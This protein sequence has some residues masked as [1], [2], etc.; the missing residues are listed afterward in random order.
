[1]DPNTGKVT[2][3]PIPVLKKGFPMGTLDLQ[4]DKEQ[5]LWVSL[6]YQGGIAKFD[7]KTEQFQVYPI[8]KEWQGNGTQ[9]SMVSPQQHRQDRCENQRV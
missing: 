2:E 9:Q 3:F 1:M 6:M 5:N 8:P 4:L 7:R